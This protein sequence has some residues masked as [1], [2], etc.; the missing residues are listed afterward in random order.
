MIKI[1]QITDPHLLEDQNDSFRDVK[2]F[3]TLKLV[4]DRIKRSNWG[5]DM[6]I[7][8]G[9]LT[10]DN[11]K[12]SYIHYIKLLESLNTPIYTIP[13]NHDN[14]TIMRSVLKKPLFHY[15]DEL[16]MHNWLIIGID[17]SKEH[18]PSG[19]ISQKELQRLKSSI[20][21]TNAKY[22]MI[23]LH[24]Q[25]ININS[26]WIDAIGLE[27]KNELY[28]ILN[29]NKKIRALFFG[30]IHQSIEMHYG[31]IQVIGTPSTCRQFKPNSNSFAMDNSPP[32]YR[33]IQLNQNGSIDTN[34]VWLNQ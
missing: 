29:N 23:Y 10:Q 31:D 16:V 30:H 2:P 18:S 21:S 24:H 3:E 17:S 33:E 27:N 11:T 20:K 26:R 19:N 7:A 22:I 9:D 15:C 6:V 13:G 12:E 4:I 28:E 8:T 32:G 14:K 25:P 5:C 34:V 1:I